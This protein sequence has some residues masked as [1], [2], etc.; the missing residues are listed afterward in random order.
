MI[1]EQLAVGFLCILTALFG[2]FFGYIFGT[3]N[4][5]GCFK[6]NDEKEKEEIK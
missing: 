3:L 4:T 2:L 5:K 6:K 1:L